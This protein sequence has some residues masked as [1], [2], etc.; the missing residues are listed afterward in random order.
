MKTWK[1]V[2]GTALVA[3][4]SASALAQRFAHEVE[5]AVLEVAQ[6]AVD[7]LG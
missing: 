7:Q 5:F 2:L 6:A 3:A 1:I 4:Y